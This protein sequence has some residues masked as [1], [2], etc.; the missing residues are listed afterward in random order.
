MQLP[1]FSEVG[2]AAK[3][4]KTLENNF[5]FFNGEVSSLHLVMVCYSMCFTQIA[6]YKYNQYKYD[7]MTIHF[8]SKAREYT[9]NK[10]SVLNFLK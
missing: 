8:S 7:A 5:L 9:E 2:F 10:K 4:T 6:R 3:A 1:R